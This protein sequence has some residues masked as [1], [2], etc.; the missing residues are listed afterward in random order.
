[1]SCPQFAESISALADGSLPASERPRV[2]VHLEACAGC[3]QLLED[4]RSLRA[5]ARRFE[6]L[7]VPDSLWPRLAARLRDQG[8]TEPKPAPSR[9]TAREWMGIAAV[10]VAAVALALFFVRGERTEPAD[11][12]ASHSGAAPADER[13]N[14]A[15]LASVEGIEAELKLAEQHYERAIAGLQQVAASDGTL[16][17]EV[18]ETVQR[19]LQVIDRAIAESRTAL[20]AEPQNRPARES[21]FEA[22]R[23]KIVLLQDTIALMNEM[24]KG[25][26]AGAG[27]IVEGL[28]KS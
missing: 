1:M 21:L 22:L 19:N 10:L 12:Q 5:E 23:R 25:N 18:A 13:G 20:N 14:L 8:V 15:P 4:L 7:P 2:E 16:D 3:R 6:M 27:E 24:R 26:Q 11:E 9:S 28:D 17:P